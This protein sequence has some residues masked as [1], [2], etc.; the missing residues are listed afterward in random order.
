MVETFCRRQDEQFG[1]EF[2]VGIFAQKIFYEP[3]VLCF[4]DAAG[5]VADSAFWFQHFRSGSEQACLCFCQLFY[6]LWAYSVADLD[7]LCQYAGIRA[8]D[9]QKDTIECR[10]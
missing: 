9:I 4:L 8:G 2:E 5:A 10:I 6:R 7:A 1:L 3:A